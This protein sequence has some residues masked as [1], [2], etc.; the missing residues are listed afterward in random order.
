M[1]LFLP[2]ISVSSPP[3]SLSD[4]SSQHMILIILSLEKKDFL[5]S[6]DPHGVT[7]S[8]WLLSFIL[9]VHVL[10]RCVYTCFFSFLPDHQSWA[11][12]HLAF[13]F[14][15]QPFLQELFLLRSHPSFICSIN[16]YWVSA[17]CEAR[18][19]EQEKSHSWVV[20]LLQ[21][22]KTQNKPGEVKWGM[23]G[24]AR[25]SC[26]GDR[27]RAWVWQVTS[28]I[29]EQPHRKPGG[30]GN[31]YLPPPACLITSHFLVSVSRRL[32]ILFYLNRPVGSF[33]PTIMTIIL[34]VSPIATNFL[35]IHPL[36]KYWY[37]WRFHSKTFLIIFSVIPWGNLL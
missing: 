33:I 30:P 19:L 36:L 17:V 37:S 21:L 5:L 22:R 35:I 7:D 15:P 26:E 29:A 13:L 28:P 20:H 2:C 6:L 12:C 34:P 23:W 8:F 16:I 24:R 1:G 10:Q 4:L 11:L 25:S 9:Y 18:Q 27:V 31:L 14:H 32:Y 3:L